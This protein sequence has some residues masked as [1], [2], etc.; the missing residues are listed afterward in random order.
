MSEFKSYIVNS[1]CFAGEQ[2]LGQHSVIVLRHK[3]LLSYN[4][5]YDITNPLYVE[6]GVEEGLHP[7]LYIINEEQYN[8]LVEGKGV[9]PQSV[10]EQMGLSVQSEQRLYGLNFKTRWDRKSGS[11]S[12]KR[13]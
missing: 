8:D 5:I 7:A 4:M 11:S 9:E 3:N 6:D 10:Y 1:F 13:K 12:K 2:S